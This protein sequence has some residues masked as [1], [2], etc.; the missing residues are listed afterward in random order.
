MHLPIFEITLSCTAILNGV[1]PF[2]TIDFSGPRRGQLN[3]GWCCS[4]AQSR[5]IS[6]KKKKKN[7]KKKQD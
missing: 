7:T 3:L 1:A 2:Y 4:E 6:S 5:G